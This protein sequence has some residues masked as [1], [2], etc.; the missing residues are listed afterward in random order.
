MTA[1][2]NDPSDIAFDKMITAAFETCDA[3]TNF[4]SHMEDVRRNA[5]AGVSTPDTEAQTL[6]GAVHEAHDRYFT[7]MCEFQDLPCTCA[8]CHAEEAAKV[9]AAPAVQPPAPPPAQP[10]K[11]PG[12]AFH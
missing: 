6:V 12:R 8:T 10:P 3:L 5:L 9:P 1:A 4:Y 2:S 11:V 7:A